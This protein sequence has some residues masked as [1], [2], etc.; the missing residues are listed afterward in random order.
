LIEHSILAIALVPRIAHA[1]LSALAHEV[2]AAALV[3]QLRAAGAEKRPALFAELDLSLEWLRGRAGDA[4]ENFSHV[5]RLI[6]A[7]RAWALDDFSTASSAF[8]AALREVG[9]TSPRQRALVAERAARC[10]LERGLER[11]G[12]LLLSEAHALYGAWG[13]TAKVRL[14]EAEHPFL[15]AAAAAGRAERHADAAMTL[16]SEGIDMVGLL[17]AS[18]ALSSQTSLP[19]LKAQVVDIL[20][21]LTGATSVLVVIRDESGE[22]LVSP[23]NDSAEDAMPIRE[24]GERG[25]LPRTAFRYVVRTGKPLLLADAMHDDRFARDPYFAG[26]AQCSLL[27]VPISIQGEPSA[28]LLL[29]NRLGRDAFSA[30]RLDAVLLIAGQLSVSLKNAML[31]ASLER[32]VAQRT[33]ALE[34]ANQRLAELSR[35][36]A[37]TGLLNRRGFDE[38]L[39][40]ACRYAVRRK[41]SVGLAMIDIDEFKKYN[42]RYGHPAGDACLRRLGATLRDGVRP[43]SDLAGRY[44]GEEFVL[45]F[46]DT[47][48][49]GVYAATER[50]RAAV[51]ELGLPHEDSAHGVVTVSIGITAFVPSNE[52]DVGR[53]LEAADVALYEAKRAGQ[54]LVVTSDRIETRATRNGAA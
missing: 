1:P 16:S 23:G 26:C 30:A 39:A 40:A 14:L 27:V 25:L 32:K 37:L 34:S 19:R 28:M 35:T 10:Y 46:P 31:Y 42:D 52:T 53:H 33:E 15:I 9:S 36:D 17:R 21:A 12:R 3:R 18:Q 20:A 41:W 5:V 49:A 24:A 48:L 38:G 6:E 8:E 44:G 2:R 29:E 47:D 11:F 51:A 45:A 54:N 50:L 13:A 7:E 43:S 4:P 22:W